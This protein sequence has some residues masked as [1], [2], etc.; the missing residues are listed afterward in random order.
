[1][2][3]W[4]R[5]NL[6]LLQNRSKGIWDCIL[7]ENNFCLFHT[8]WFTIIAIRRKRRAIKARNT[9]IEAERRV[10]G[11]KGAAVGVEAEESEVVAEIVAEDVVKVV[12]ETVAEDVVKVV[13][14][15]AAKDLVEVGEEIVVN[16]I[17]VEIGVEVAVEDV[18]VVEAEN[19]NVNAVEIMTGSVGVVVV[20]KGSENEETRA[21]LIVQYLDRWLRSFKTTSRSIIF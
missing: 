12:A 17:I 18:D 15:I 3:W 14:E 8:I 5:W 6:W 7:F 20:M 9:E 11:V 21:Y 1:M 16:D 19:A 2:I 13:A 4:L 10:G